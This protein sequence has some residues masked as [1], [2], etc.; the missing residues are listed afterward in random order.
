MILD[1]DLRID[2]TVSFCIILFHDDK[3]YKS[4][5]I[6]NFRNIQDSVILDVYHHLF[7]LVHSIIDTTDACNKRR[8]LI[9]VGGYKHPI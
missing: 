9:V 6:S 3:I 4:D 5:L 2:D 1:Q 8:T 7:Y